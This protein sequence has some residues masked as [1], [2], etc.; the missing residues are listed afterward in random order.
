[1]IGALAL[2]AAGRALAALPAGAL[3]AH[4][5]A[6][7]T[8]LD[9]GLG[10]IAGVRALR[11]WPNE[12][13]RIGAVTFVVAGFAAE[14]V[15]QYLSAEYGIGVRDGRFCA[16]PLLA[17]LNAD[18]SAVRAS[19]GIGSS[20]EDV[21]RLVQAVS[22]LRRRGPRW[23]YAA[24]EGDYRPTPDSRELPPWM[25]ADAAGSGSWCGG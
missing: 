4:E 19:I 7:L 14:F 23:T 9:D 16:H 25:N 13:D 18:S 24:A 10:Q 1:V 22:D 11:L 3:A 15:A 12:A 20:S 2:A 8:R 17:R 5:E 21:D 6:L